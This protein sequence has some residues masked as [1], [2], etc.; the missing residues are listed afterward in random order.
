MLFL[1]SVDCG[2][3]TA[4]AAA[5]VILIKSIRENQ[6]LVTKPQTA[7]RSGHQNSGFLLQVL[8]FLCFPGGTEGPFAAVHPG[9]S[10]FQPRCPLIRDSRRWTARPGFG[11]APDR[12]IHG[13][14]GW[15]NRQAHHNHRAGPGW[16]AGT[17][18]AAEEGCRPGPGHGGLIHPRIF[19]K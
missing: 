7:H 18:G 9:L 1:R 5:A 13:E 11:A 8:L 16:P 12:R 19:L 17:G 15:Q 2:T 10:R 6:A 3:C 14:A 4:G